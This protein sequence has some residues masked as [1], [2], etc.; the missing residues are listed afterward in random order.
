VTNIYQ[1]IG[2]RVSVRCSNVVAVVKYVKAV[3]YQLVWLLAARS[4]GY[5]IWTVGE[6]PVRAR[7]GPN[8][9]LRS[10]IMSLWS[11]PT[12]GPT[13]HNIGIFG[14]TVDLA[15]AKLLQDMREY[16]SST[17]VLLLLLLKPLDTP[18][19]LVPYLA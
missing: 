18:G 13:R 15:S 7:H 19:D 3:L 10:D 1:E 4:S 12:E 5:A 6:L 16:V 9:L 2:W 11:V 17:L 14:M 8:F